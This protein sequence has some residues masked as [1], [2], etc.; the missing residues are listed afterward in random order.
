MKQHLVLTTRDPVI[1][2]DG[3]PFGLGNRMRPLSWLYPSVLAGAL[4]SLLG[5]M[6][7]KGFD[8]DTIQ[9]LK[10]VHVAGPLPLL[11]GSLYF[12]APKDLAVR[13]NEA[14]QLECYAL[15]PVSLG[16]GEGTDLP[17]EGLQPVLLPDAVTGE[18]KPERIPEFWSRDRMAEWLKSPDRAPASLRPEPGAWGEGYLPGPAT[19][20]RTHVMITP[21]RG[22]AE[23]AHLFSTVG[24]DLAAAADRPPSQSAY[25]PLRLGV[26]TCA[27]DRWSEALGKL[28]RL[29]PMGGERRLVHWEARGDQ[30]PWEA[31]QSVVQAL[32][33]EGSG[34]KARVRMVLATP[35]L[36][37][38]GWR[39]GWLDD[40]LE[41]SPPGAEVRLRLVGACLDR[42]KPVS[43]FSFE[44]WKPKPIRR[45]VPAGAVYFF[46]VIEGSVSPQQLWLESVCDEEQDRRDGFGLALWGIWD[47][48]KNGNCEELTP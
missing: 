8:E 34:R 29:S 31:P 10:E 6:E 40:R 25:S 20:E 9:A 37:R 33:T 13:K 47:N 24:L 44:D 48:H 41:G 11:G 12:P 27:G 39:P 43:G 21:D 4:R 2:R 18:F 23:D 3:R 46:E 30:G 1:A 17:G 38:R 19:D 32:G 28:N 26:R 14:G 35:G 22:A 15:R 36:F 42:W 45:L 7:G 5:K 16:D